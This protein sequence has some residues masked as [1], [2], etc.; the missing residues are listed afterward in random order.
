MRDAQSPVQVLMHRHLAAR[1]SGAPNPLQM[2]AEIAKADRFYNG[3]EQY[4]IQ[5]E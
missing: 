2:Q 4:P 3:A 1:Q 5:R